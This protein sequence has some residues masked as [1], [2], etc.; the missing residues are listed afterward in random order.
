[1][2]TLLSVLHSALFSGRDAYSTYFMFW[3]LLHYKPA[4]P[5]SILAIVTFDGQK[6]KKYLVFEHNFH[7]EDT[8]VSS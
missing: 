3:N 1:M 4:G 6:H 8:K 2:I 7:T 5:R